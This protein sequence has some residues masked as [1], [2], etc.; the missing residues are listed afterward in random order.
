MGEGMN[1]NEWQKACMNKY[2]NEEYLMM[3]VPDI[4]VGQIWGNAL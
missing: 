2:I 4:S 1:E 3:I